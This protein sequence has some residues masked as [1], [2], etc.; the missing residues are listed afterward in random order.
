MD[1]SD[2]ADAESRYK[3]WLES[4][5]NEGELPERGRMGEVPAGAR[6]V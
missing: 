4:L 6:G 5:N 3:T 2:H 1:L